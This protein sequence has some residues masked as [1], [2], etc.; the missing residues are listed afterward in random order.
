MGDKYDAR[1]RILDLCFFRHLLKRNP[2]DEDEFCWFVGVL[3]E[4][5]KILIEEES[6]STM[7]YDSPQKG[8]RDPSFYCDD[9]RHYNYDEGNAHED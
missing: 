7:F 9:D 8:K 1:S 2:I 3:N 4:R 6:F 5:E